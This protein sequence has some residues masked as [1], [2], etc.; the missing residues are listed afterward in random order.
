MWNFF[1][2]LWRIFL[3]CEVFNKWPIPRHICFY[4]AGQNYEEDESGRVIGATERKHS[5]DHSSV[6]EREVSGSRKAMNE[7]LLFWFCGLCICVSKEVFKVSR[8]FINAF[9]AV[10]DNAKLP[11][12]LP[13]LDL[14]FSVSNVAWYH[15]MHHAYGTS[16]ICPASWVFYPKPSVMGQR[17]FCIFFNNVI[18]LK[19]ISYTFFP[20][21]YMKAREMDF[22]WSVLSTYFSTHYTFSVQ[23]NAVKF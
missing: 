8:E 21:F 9:R 14:C 5:A 4:L 6:S 10:F 15:E 20:P 12:H 3:R 2:F 16:G 22:R 17:D 19:R 23:G 11:S 1:F 7:K 13:Q 18:S